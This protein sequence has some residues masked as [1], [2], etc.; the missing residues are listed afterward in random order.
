MKE[1]AV[2]V[3]GDIGRSPRMV[4]HSL[5]LAE[6]T[7]FRVNLFAYLGTISGQLRQ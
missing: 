5:E 2:V 6:N 4:N 7:N 1:C 3:F